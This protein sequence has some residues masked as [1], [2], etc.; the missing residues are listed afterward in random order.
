VNFTNALGLIVML[1]AVVLAVTVWLGSLLIGWLGRLAL[2]QRAYEDA[3]ATHAVKTGTPTMGG[4]LFVLAL[5]APLLLFP[6]FL[7]FGRMFAVALIVL[8]VGCGA[9]G[10]LDD[11]MSI[12]RGRNRGLRA[13]TKLLLTAIVAVLFLWIVHG[14]IAA[15]RATNASTNWDGTFFIFVAPGVWWQASTIAW[16]LVS[17][18]V[19]L[20]TTHA[21]NLTDG[22]DGLLG[23]SILMPLIALLVIGLTVQRP[24]FLSPSWSELV[25]V[26]VIIPVLVAA[27]IGFLYYNIHPARLFMGDTGSLTLGGILAGSAIML[28]MQF[29]LIVI[30]GI[31]VAEA[32]SV[33]LQVASFKLTGKRIF[34]MSPLHHHFE[35]GGWP[36][37]RV[38]LR[39][40]AASAI[41]SAAGVALYLVPIAR[42]RL[43]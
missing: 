18:A 23:G 43:L 3:P 14:A 37:E 34:R 17:L 41:C 7:E 36:E 8:G 22:L 21:A 1:A 5:L 26:I 31:F 20:A 42:M 12:R 4:L 27:V 30:G 13:R 10:F 9:V 2:R 15:D 32:L 39:F 25:P 6:P 29:L 11:Y 35:L 24:H 40:W 19:I 16:A 38:T 28:G 33:I